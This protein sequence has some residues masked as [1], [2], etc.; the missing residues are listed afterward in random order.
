MPASGPA[1]VIIRFDDWM[2]IG[3]DYERLSFEMETDAPMVKQLGKSVLHAAL[4]LCGT[5]RTHLVE[6][7]NTS[8]L[9]PAPPCHLL[10][11]TGC[12]GLMLHLM[13]C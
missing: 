1:P 7:C 13:L 10:P 2:V 12:V 4:P 3:S 11:K 5:W 9:L 6:H 8:C